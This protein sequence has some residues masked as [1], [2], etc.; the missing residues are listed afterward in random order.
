M[1]ISRSE[2]LLE[3]INRF[4]LGSPITSTHLIGIPAMTLGGKVIGTWKALQVIGQF[5]WLAICKYTTKHIDLATCDNIVYVYRI[6]VGKNKTFHCYYSTLRPI[7]SHWKW[8]RAFMVRAPAMTD[9]I[10]C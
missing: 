5:D 9:S 8:G 7:N 6:S 10:W 1:K 3:P 4:R 2:S